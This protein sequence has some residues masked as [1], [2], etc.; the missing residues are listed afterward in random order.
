MEQGASHPQASAGTPLRAAR[1]TASP[2]GSVRILE[3]EGME[4]LQAAILGAPIELTQM[5]AGSLRSRFVS[6]Q[7]GDRKVVWQSLSKAVR[8]RGIVPPGWVSL[9]VALRAP[10]PALYGDTQV[11]S[12]GVLAYGPG[13][14]YEAFTPAGFEWASFH[15]Q[16]EEFASLVEGIPRAASSLPRDGARVLP[17]GPATRD[18]LLR[19]ARASEWAAGGPTGSEDAHDLLERWTQAFAEV[20]DVSARSDAIPT[21]AAGALILERAEDYLRA[22]LAESVY[23]RDLCTACSTNQR[24]L[25]NVFRERLGL[26]PFEYLRTLRLN[27]V[28]RELVGRSGD[29]TASVAEVAKRW[30]LLH[31]GR[32]SVDYRAHFGESPSVTLHAR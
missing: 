16:A 14:A 25:Q 22:H 5:S 11:V 13:A 7:D 8:G 26:T 19:L 4:S 31:P 9:V 20:L 30:G 32:L 2:A 6:S 24:T 3:V 12:G 1:R 10:A 15:L 27:Q 23:L 21:P 28:R 29:P 18:G 17:V